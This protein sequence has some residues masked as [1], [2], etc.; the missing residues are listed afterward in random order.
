MIAHHAL[1][2][3]ACQKRFDKSNHGGTVGT[4]ICQVAEKD[5]AP[6]IRVNTIE[7][8]EVIQQGAKGIDLAV[9]V[10]DHIDRT[11]E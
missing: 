5:E 11:R 4:A 9:N 6:A 2:K 10:G 7:I 3:A 1:G 8:A